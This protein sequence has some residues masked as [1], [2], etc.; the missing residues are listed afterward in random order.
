ML[1]NLVILFYTSGLRASGQTSC[2]RATFV[3]CHVWFLE[4]GGNILSR[5]QAAW[6]FWC[7]WC[8]CNEPAWCCGRS[9][10]HEIR[11]ERCGTA[12]RQ[13][14]RQ[15]LKTFYLHSMHVSLGANIFSPGVLVLTQRFLQSGK[16][17]VA[18][19]VPSISKFLPA[20][21]SKRYIP[22]SSS[23]GAY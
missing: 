20:G 3:R 23:L 19:H 4:T 2:L 22:I 15:S 21:L 14:Q 11:C 18:S 9:A 10:S 1:V 6:R 5:L 17:H 12:T 8:H 13:S 7:S 16:Q